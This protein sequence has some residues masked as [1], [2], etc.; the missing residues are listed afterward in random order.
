MSIFIIIAVAFML[1]VA[2]LI[3]NIAVVFWGIICIII[4]LFVSKKMIGSNL[5]N[6]ITKHLIIILIIAMSLMIVI[7]FG[8]KSH[9][10]VP[11]NIQGLD[12]IYSDNYAEYCVENSYY[13]ISDM[14]SDE[15]FINHNSKGFIL[16]ISYLIR[17]S[18]YLGGYDTIILRM[19]N[20]SFLIIIGIIMFSY[21]MKKNNFTFNQNLKLLYFITL[22]P[23]SLYISSHV[24]RDT[25]CATFIIYCFYI[26]DNYWERDKLSKAKIIIVTILLMYISYWFRS[27]NIL[28]LC[29][30][31][32]INLLRTGLKIKF[33]NKIKIKKI[34]YFTLGSLALVIAILY[35][36]KDIL[37][38]QNRY[39]VNYTD[40]I[41]NANKGGRSLSLIVYSYALFPFGIILRTIYYLCSPFMPDIM[42]VFHYFDN[43]TTFVNVLISFG[44]ILLIMNFTYLAKNIKYQDKITVF[45]EIIFISII[46]TTMGFRHVIM[47]YP[48]MFYMIMRQYN[49]TKKKKKVEYLILSLGYSVIG[50]IIYF[51]LR[52]IM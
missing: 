24:Y 26:W 50:I 2:L 47:I 38:W 21:S 8:Y 18:N 36:G 48:L 49:I 27:A 44:T 15:V 42:N 5:H 7:Y 28:Y 32:I 10:G 52:Y 37:Y 16:F 6:K 25:I 34:I 19:L 30:A 31:I 41:L 3:S 33:S 40:L 23:N 11:Y 29:I 35:L 45:F 39:I 17:I 1:F 4:I 9:Y 20:I 12:D 51:T 14:L 46:I 22:F 13:T 43:I